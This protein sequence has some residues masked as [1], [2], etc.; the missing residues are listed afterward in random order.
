MRETQTYVVV[1]GN[2][3]FGH[4]IY[5]TFPSKEAAVEWC[6]ETIAEYVQEH[7]ERPTTEMYVMPV[8]PATSM[9]KEWFL[10]N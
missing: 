4:G 7:G 9:D 3:A 2:F 6:E 1:V 5:G 8:A 10:Q